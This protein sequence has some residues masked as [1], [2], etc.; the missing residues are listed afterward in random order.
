MIQIEVMF[1]L[2]FAWYS[3]NFAQS[4]ATDC[5]SKQVPHLSDCGSVVVIYFMVLPPWGPDAD[6]MADISRKDSSKEPRQSTEYGH[7]AD[8]A[9]GE[10]LGP[11]LFLLYVLCQF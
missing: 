3:Q 10:V 8:S 2:F 5:V 11:L 7:Y 9:S 4:E 6:A 1:L